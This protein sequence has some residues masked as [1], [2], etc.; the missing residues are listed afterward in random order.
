[1]KT[2]TKK[3]TKKDQ[4]SAVTLNYRV[5]KNQDFCVTHDERVQE[6]QLLVVTHGET[7]PIIMEHQRRRA[8]IIKMMNAQKSQIMA[9]ITR[10]IGYNSFQ[11]EKERKQKWD[12]AGKIFDA[13]TKTGEIPDGYTEIAKLCIPPAMAVNTSLTQLADERKNIEKEMIDCV[14]S[15]PVCDWWIAMK[16]R[17]YLGL[18]IIIGESGNLS[19][20]PNPAKLWK[21]FGLAVMDG[22]RQGGLSKTAKAEEWIEHGYCKR[23]RS[24]IWTIGD[25][26]IKTNQDK[27]T[28]EIGKYRQLYLDRKVIEIDRLK[29]EQV[30]LGLK[31]DDYKLI[32]AH[33]RAQRYMEKRLLLDLWNY[34]NGK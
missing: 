26:L 27:K 28:G 25:C 31:E 23:R 7:V 2:K 20:Y 21:R 11:D 15:L 9:Y 5:K 16:G 4:R 12:L 19:D 30:E 32:I 33:R 1:M 22:V 10:L 29:K 3:K 34:W 18:A 17:S 14:R 24:I 6:N 8:G 13:I